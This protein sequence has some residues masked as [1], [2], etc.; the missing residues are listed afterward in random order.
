MS[1]NSGEELGIPELQLGG[2]GGCLPIASAGSSEQTVPAWVPSLQ[3]T[4]A[5]TRSD[6]LEGFSVC[7]V[8]L[9]TLSPLTAGFEGTVPSHLSCSYGFSA[10]AGILQ[11]QK[12]GHSGRSCHPNHHGSNCVPLGQSPPNLRGVVPG[13]ART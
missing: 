7:A 10:L 9:T 8:H 3:G 5:F 1:V 4:G 12:A 6:L 11:T 2:L 13:A